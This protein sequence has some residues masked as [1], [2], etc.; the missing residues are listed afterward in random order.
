MMVD[1][2]HQW[3]CILVPA[4]TDPTVI[5]GNL[6]HHLFCSV[7]AVFNVLEHLGIEQSPTKEP[8]C[9]GTQPSWG[10]AARSHAEPCGAM[11]SHGEPW[12]LSVELFG[13]DLVTGCTI[14][15]VIG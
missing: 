13:T 7:T 5:H 12:A 6:V 15:L 3:T 11:E 10:L 2:H 4:V 9:Q 1:V 8:C 14:L